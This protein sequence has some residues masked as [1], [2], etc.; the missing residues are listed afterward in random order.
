VFTARYALSPRIKQIRFVFKGIIHF[1]CFVTFEFFFVCSDECYTK[2]PFFLHVTL[3]IIW[4]P[5]HVFVRRYYQ[6]IKCVGS[7]YFTGLYT[8]IQE[9]FIYCVQSCKIDVAFVVFIEVRKFSLFIVKLHFTK[10]CRGVAVHVH[11]FLI[12]VLDE[13][14]KSGLCYRRFIPSKASLSSR[15]EVKWNQGCLDIMEKR[16]AFVG[17]GNRTRISPPPRP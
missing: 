9:H 8:S 10:M 13:K 1:L 14:E 6:I 3:Q 16:S 4:V 2:K 7:N 17:A 5:C 15:S 12:S 11:K